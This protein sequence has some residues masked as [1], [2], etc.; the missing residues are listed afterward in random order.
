MAT[1][2]LNMEVS[3]YLDDEGVAVAVYL[4]EEEDGKSVTISFDDLFDDLINSVDVDND[5]DDKAYVER[6]ATQLADL[7]KDL[8]C[9]IG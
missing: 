9:Q 5:K 4:N 6:I 2:E 8:F 7:S 3:A 1:V